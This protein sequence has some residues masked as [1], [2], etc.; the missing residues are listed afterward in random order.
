MRRSVNWVTLV[1]LAALSAAPARLQGGMQ[2]DAAAALS[3]VW[4]S[5][6]SLSPLAAPATVN[7]AAGPAA[8][9]EMLRDSS[10]Q[11]QQWP[12]APELVVLTSVMKY[13]TGEP[14]EYV[15][16]S[17]RVSAEDT[18]G[19]VADLTLAL[20]QLTNDTF[21]Q[22]ATVRYEAV[23]PGSSVNVARPKQIVVGRYKGLHAMAQTLG[24]GGRS[25]RRNG[26][27]TSAAIVLDSEFD[28]TSELRGLLRTHELGHALGYNHV[29]SRVSIMNPRI[30]PD[31]TDFDRQ[32]VTLAF[33]PAR[34]RSV[35]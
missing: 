7:S 18:Q 12:S 1:A 5:P 4:G 23:P 24:F 9:D 13:Q 3:P 28:R 22:F 32:V 10:G 8:L 27:I 20:R 30:G 15:A 21:M 2:F 26:A 33:G 19:L 34:F 31:V 35:E 6:S 29:K 11:R 17:E 25:A 16:T 14:R